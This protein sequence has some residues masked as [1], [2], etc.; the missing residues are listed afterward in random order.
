MGNPDVWS[1][2]R[3]SLSRN[4][5]TT[6][7]EVITEISGC[8]GNIL[9]PPSPWAA[10]VAGP[11]CFSELV[12]R[13]SLLPWQGPSVAPRAQGAASIRGPDLLLEA[14][15]K[16]TGLDGRQWRGCESWGMWA[17]N[18]PRGS[19][20]AYGH[21][22][23]RIN[24]PRPLDKAKDCHLH[25]HVSLQPP[26]PAMPSS[27]LRPVPVP[28]SMLRALPQPLLAPEAKF[29]DHLLRQ[30]VTSKSHRL[31]FKYQLS[32]ILAG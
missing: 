7:C 32:Y 6:S 15:R 14:P 26:L 3:K 17:G 29:R 30:M 31:R 19:P 9:N 25:I 22:S 20:W 12:P 10:V 8:D 4:S 16:C 2:Q 5:G 13:L 1:S 11:L 27:H 28:S 24:F 23:G 21:F 18:G